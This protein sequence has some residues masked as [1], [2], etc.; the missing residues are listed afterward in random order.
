M[1][2]LFYRL[3]RMGG[4]AAVG[5]ADRRY[6]RLFGR[7][8]NAVGTGSFVGTRWRGQG[9]STATCSHRLNLQG[10]FHSLDMGGR[11]MPHSR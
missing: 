3:K 1:K 7:C 8:S 11:R 6:L 9:Y 2:R 5:G 10:D 4:M